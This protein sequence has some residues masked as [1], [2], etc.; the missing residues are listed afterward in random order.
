MINEGRDWIGAESPG[1]APM[2]HCIGDQMKI[3]Y[4]GA[5]YE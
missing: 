3:K 5:K 4:L 2:L 1:C